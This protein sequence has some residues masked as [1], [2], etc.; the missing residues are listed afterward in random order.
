MPRGSHSCSS[1]CECGKHS[2]EF[3][4]TMSRVNTGRIPWNK[5][6]TCAPET[7]KKIGEK[8][9]GRFVSEETKYKIQKAGE[10]RRLSEE[11]KNNISR[12]NKDQVPWHK[13][14]IGVY[15]KDSLN[16]MSEAQARCLANRTGPYRDT[17]PEKS[18]ERL[19]QDSGLC[20]EKQKWIKR[21]CVDFYLPQQ[22]LVIEVDGCYI[23]SCP[24]HFLN[25]GRHPD[26]FEKR[27]QI[28]N[29]LGY[30]AIRIWEHELKE[31]YAV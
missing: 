20:F 5:G 30:G 9:Q 10:G 7:R 1:T 28:L 24:E 8:A 18:L 17:L 19:L 21:M 11:H 2:S 26:G 23:H 4:R 27:Q 15:S 14:K 3:R 13:G 31:N 25:R 22:N 12:A 6:V 29:E 16:K